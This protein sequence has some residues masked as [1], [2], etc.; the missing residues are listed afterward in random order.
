MTQHASIAESRVAVHE[1]AHAIAGVL[2]G[3]KVLYATVKRTAGVLGKVER[4]G[5]V[6]SDNL[7][8][9]VWAGPIADAR[10]YGS[11]LPGGWDGDRNML[12]GIDVETRRRAK[13]KAE[14]IVTQYWRHIF[15][16]ASLLLTHKTIPGPHIRQLVKQP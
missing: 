9:M 15:H 6:S 4:T 14:Q 2:L 7:A 13:A 12:S 5:W 16:L 10:A 3:V 11:P 8:A 1:G